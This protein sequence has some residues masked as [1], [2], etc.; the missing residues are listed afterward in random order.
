MDGLLRL[1]VADAVD[2]TIFWRRLSQ[3]VAQNDFAPVRDLFIDR[4][5]L[6]AWLLSY[7]EL[8]ALIDKGLSANLMLKTN[9]K[10]ILRNHVGEQAIRAA[11]Q[12]DFGE[13]RTLQTLLARPFD[14]H[15]GFEAYANFPPA[16]ASTISI[17][18]SS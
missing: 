12:G 13:L 8:T 14:E 11:Q 16:W 6:D 5:A 4:T 1:L 7:Q 18:C 17:S 15:P 3:G 9:P 2:Y 10:F